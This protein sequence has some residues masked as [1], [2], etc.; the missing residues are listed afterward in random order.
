MGEARSGSNVPSPFPRSPLTW[1]SRSLVT[2]GSSRPSR[3]RSAT[4]TEVGLPPSGWGAAEA[5]F[6]RSVHAVPAG[7]GAVRVAAVSV[8]GVSFVAVLLRRDH[9]IATDELLG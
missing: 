2:A 9:V 7:R 6:S 3:L 1:S 4:R 8:D 5:E